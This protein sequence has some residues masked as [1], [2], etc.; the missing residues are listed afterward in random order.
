MLPELA[1][2]HGEEERSEPAGREQP[3]AGARYHPSSAD[4]LRAATERGDGHADDSEGEAGALDGI[5]RLADGQP[6]QDRHHWCGRGDRRD[7][8]HRAHGQP[9]VKGRDPGCLTE[10]SERGVPDGREAG[11]ARLSG[12][13]Q[14]RQQDEGRC[15]RDQ[16]HREQ[17]HGPALHPAEV[18]GQPPPETRPQ[19]QEYGK[20]QRW[21]P[22]AGTNEP[23]T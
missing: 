21:R 11:R 14:D 2:A 15:L 23:A 6:R 22:I 10:P 1:L 5:G 8:A 13:Q 20:H 12:E 18:V 3:V 9:T 7:K 17:R 16:Q 19:G 4:V